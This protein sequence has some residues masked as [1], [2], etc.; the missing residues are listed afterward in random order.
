MTMRGY[1]AQAVSDV[2]DA[3][4]HHRR[5]LLQLPTGAG[6]THCAADIVQRAHAMN[7]KVLMVAPRRELVFQAADKLESCGMHPDIIMAGE[8]RNLYGDVQVAS[9][10]TLAARRNRGPLPD[11]DLLIVDEAHTAITDARMDIMAQYPRVIGLTATPARSDG[12]GQ[13]GRAP[14]REGEETAG[15]R[16]A[17]GRDRG[18]IRPGKERR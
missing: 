12:R 7:R 1:Q 3:M 17:A 10:D 5:V 16:G 6:K 13:I 8:P 11:A 4:R 15:V 2:R 14:G 18:D 9:F